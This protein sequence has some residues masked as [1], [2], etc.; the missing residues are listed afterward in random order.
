MTRPRT[1]HGFS[2]VEPADRWPWPV[3][4]DGDGPPVLL[5]HELFGLS[6]DAL[7]FARELAGAGFSVWLPVFAGP[8]PSYTR[9]DRIRAVAGICVSR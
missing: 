1:V 8:A 4:R 9:V 5:L 7:R 3:Y 6:E 2:L